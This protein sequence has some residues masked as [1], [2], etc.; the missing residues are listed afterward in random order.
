MDL[1][2]R[3]GKFESSKEIVRHGPA[4]MKLRALYVLGL[5]SILVGIQLRAQVLQLRA[6]Y[7]PFGQAAT[8]VALS[9]D[10]F[11]VRIERCA[12]AWDPPLSIEG[13][14]IARWRDRGTYFEWD[15]AMSNVDGYEQEALEACD[16]RTA[17]PTMIRMSCINSDGGRSETRFRCP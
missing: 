10:M 7:R 12:V 11:A 6:G 2:A 1:G 8:R 16:Y 9:W 14:S 3:V 13:K 17:T 5:C 15:T 4:S